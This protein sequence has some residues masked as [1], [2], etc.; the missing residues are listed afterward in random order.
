MG[1]IRSLVSL[2]RKSVDFYNQQSDLIAPILKPVR[3]TLCAQ[4]T[5]ISP[6]I[7]RNHSSTSTLESAF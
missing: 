7:P 3:P 2:T 6:N 4:C 1:W 5:V